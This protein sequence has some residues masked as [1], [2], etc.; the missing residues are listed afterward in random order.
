MPLKE[1]VN[2][3]VNVVKVV[4]KKLKAKSIRHKA[5]WLTTLFT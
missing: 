1:G 4:L 3:Y 5:R 2:E